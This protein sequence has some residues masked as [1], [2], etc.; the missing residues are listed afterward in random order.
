[1]QAVRT[2]SGR[3]VRRRNN[4]DGFEDLSVSGTCTQSYD[5]KYK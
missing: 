5:H 2:L 3:V 4:I 1:M